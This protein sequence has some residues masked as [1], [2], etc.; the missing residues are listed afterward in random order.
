MVVEAGL[1][2]R[3]PVERPQGFAFLGEP[4]Q[5]VDRDALGPPIDR[6]AVEPAHEDRRPGGVSRRRTGVL[7]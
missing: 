2:E 3:D 6:H 4:D 5:L 1:V 7:I